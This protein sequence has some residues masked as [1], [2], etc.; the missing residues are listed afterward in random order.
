MTSNRILIQVQVEGGS[1]EWCIWVAD[2][3]LVKIL[4]GAT[5]GEETPESIDQVAGQLD[6]TK[7]SHV[8][9]G[10]LIS[11]FFF[12]AMSAVSHA[13]HARVVLSE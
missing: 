10:D 7:C 8:S 13:C 11:T 12:N 4:V 9:P 5:C 2:Q 1:D 6:R 3:E